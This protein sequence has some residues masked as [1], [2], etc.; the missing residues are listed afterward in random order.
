MKNNKYTILFDVD[1]L[2][3]S[4]CYNVDSAEDA[5]YKFDESYYNI[6]NTI[7]ESFE[8]KNVLNFGLSRGNFRKEIYSDYK[9][10]RR[11]RKLPDYWGE[12]AEHVANHFELLSPTGIETDD[13]VARESR[14]IDNTIICSIDK[15]YMQIPGLIYNYNKQKFYDV[16]EEYALRSLFTQ[17]VVGDSSDNVNFCKGY[18][19]K[20][21]DRLFK[22]CTT[23]YQFMRKTFELFKQIYKSKA[24][25]KFILCYKLL[26]I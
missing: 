12:V 15:D 16:S 19:V 21:A 5:M 11:N 20:Y 7:E 23:K 9:A 6:I 8:I 22:D 4:S 25:E 2:I 24:R 1:S 18:G 10:N 13:I 26:K 3:Y 14:K 17:M